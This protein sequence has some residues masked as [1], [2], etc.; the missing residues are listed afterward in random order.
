MGKRIYFQT[1]LVENIIGYQVFIFNH[2]ILP[3]GEDQFY[4]KGP[5]SGY[6]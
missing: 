3:K 1:D 5:A 4:Q 6:L 2:K